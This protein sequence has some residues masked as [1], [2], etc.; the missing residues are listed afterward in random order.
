MA[1]DRSENPDK[2]NRFKQLRAFC[3]AARLNGM[4]AA[5]ERLSITQPAVSQQI[6]ALERELGTSLFHRNGSRIALTPGGESL[7]RL[8]M[9]LVHGMEHLPEAFA[10]RFG[11]EVSGEVRVLAGLSAATFLLPEPLGRFQARY[12]EA[13]VTVSVGGIGESLKLIRDHEADFALGAMEVAPEDID[14]HIVRRSRFVIIAPIGHPLASVETASP[15]EIAAE[16]LILPPTGSVARQA[17]DVIARRLGLRTRI[18]VEVG[19]WALIRRYVE[20]GLGIAFVPELCV[21][22]AD[23]VRVVAPDDSMARHLGPINYGVILHRPEFLS[24][25]ARRL[26]QEIAP[27]FPDPDSD[28]ASRG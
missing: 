16:R 23:R 20:H 4:S 5:A 27:D 28:A 9:P 22:P 2:R 24:L 15:E 25:A 12:P 1:A 11:R 17:G 18:G 14:F 10:E 3:Y 26:I 6:R 21:S 7:Y 19:G 13:R 8:A